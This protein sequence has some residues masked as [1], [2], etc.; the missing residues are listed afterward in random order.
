MHPI[1]A[2]S[3]D[4][5]C[6]MFFQIYWHIVKK[7]VT[8]MVLGILRGDPIPNY[9]N[10]AFITL[11]PK[12]SNAVYMTEFRPISLCNVV[13]KLVSKVLANRLKSFLSRIISVN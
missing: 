3:P 5:M 2:L 13:Y 4:G 9:L 12:K 8:Q 6:R 1:K 7:Y 10:R 11:I